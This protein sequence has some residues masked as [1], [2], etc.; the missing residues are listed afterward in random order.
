MIVPPVAV[1]EVA[2]AS[3]NAQRVSL[4]GPP[5]RPLLKCLRAIEEPSVLLVYQLIIKH[6]KRL[7]SSQTAH[8]TYLVKIRE[9]IHVVNSGGGVSSLCGLFEA[10]LRQE[11]IV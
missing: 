10:L 1:R 9:H 3:M 11:R 2:V 6:V 8:A 7:V 4:R 5:E